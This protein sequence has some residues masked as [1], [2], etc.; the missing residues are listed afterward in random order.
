MQAHFHIFKDSFVQECSRL[1]YALTH[2]ST[3]SKVRLEKFWSSLTFFDFEAKFGDFHGQL[4]STNG[5]IRAIESF[6]IQKAEQGAVQNS[7]ASCQNA[8]RI[9]RC[10]VNLI[11]IEDVSFKILFLGPDSMSKASNQTKTVLR[12]LASLLCPTKKRTDVTK[13]KDET[14]WDVSSLLK[15]DLFSLLFRLQDDLEFRWF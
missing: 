4:W 10:H 15:M 12:R 11:K 9:I 8:S 1:S 7:F 3:V 13:V 2:R 14:C 5:S 6:V